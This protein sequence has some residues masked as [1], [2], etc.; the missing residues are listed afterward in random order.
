[1]KYFIK[2][3]WWRQCHARP[4]Y[5]S[6]L[7]IAENP[8]EYL[9]RQRKRLGDEWTHIQIDNCCQVSDD[10]VVSSDPDLGYKSPPLT[11]EQKK[12]SDRI[13]IGILCTVAFLG[14]AFAL[15]IYFGIV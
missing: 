2:L 14:C 9:E 5:S 3:H 11:P 4:G 8:T 13:A 1:M 6:N 10:A 12:R 15:G 7:T